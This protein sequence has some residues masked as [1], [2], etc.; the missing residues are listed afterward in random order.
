MATN[1]FPGIGKKGNSSY[2]PNFYQKVSVIESDFG[3]ESVDGYQPNIIIRFNTAGVIFQNEGTGVVEYSFDGWTV[4]GEL[5]STLP[6]R[7]MSFDNR[8]IS[9]IWFR[10]K[11][12]SSGPITVRVDAW[13]WA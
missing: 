2:K 7:T 12:G 9:M 1:N 6:S 5:D 4:H 13:A 11:S 10:V 8:I 3:S